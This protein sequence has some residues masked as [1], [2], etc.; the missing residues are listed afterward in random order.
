MTEPVFKRTILYCM[1]CK[2][3][4]D[5]TNAGVRNECPTCMRSSLSYVAFHEH[6]KAQADTVLTED[7]GKAVDDVLPYEET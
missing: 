1:G 2:W 3:A 4:A 7:I 6:E 5:V